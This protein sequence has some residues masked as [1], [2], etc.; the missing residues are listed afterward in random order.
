M[1]PAAARAGYPFAAS[2]P[3]PAAGRFG[4]MAAERAES[5]RALAFELRQDRLVCDEI[6]DEEWGS[7]Y[8]TPSLPLAWDASFLMVERPGFA[9]DELIELGDRLLGE[10]GFEH[11]T[12]VFDE[13]AGGVALARRFEARPGWEV[14]V[15]RHMVWRGGERAASVAVRETTLAE[16]EPLRRLLIAENLPPGAAADGRTVDQLL[17][18]DRRYCE[19]GGDR[20]FVAEADGE[21]ASACCLFE[22]DGIAQVEE[23]ATRRGARERGLG[24][25]VVLTAVEAAMDARPEMLFLVADGHD[26]PQLMYAKLGFEAVGDYQ[27]PQR[28]P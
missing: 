17:E 28:R 18:L 21:P 27:A 4:A 22:R 20:W 14:D 11:R 13:R 7:A 3:F 9:V 1:R 6:V 16:I 8:R 24:Q 10:A 26:W 23:V 19:A 15:A 5:E 25:S 2:R 12:L